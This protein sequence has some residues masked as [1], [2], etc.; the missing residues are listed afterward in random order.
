MPLPIVKTD[1]FDPLEAVQG[2]GEAGGR[3][4]PAREKDQG[5][6]MRVHGRT[7]GSGHRANTVFAG[8][9]AASAKTLKCVGREWNIGRQADC[10]L[11]KDAPDPR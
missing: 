10:L 9:Q 6:S 3:I 2:P 4:L 5:A 8:E 11:C 1:G 7:L